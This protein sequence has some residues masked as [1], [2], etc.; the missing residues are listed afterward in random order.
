MSRRSKKEAVGVALFP[1]LAVLICTMG[2]LIVLLVLMV[3]QARD[4][5]GQTLAK[6]AGVAATPVAN[7]GPSAEEL[8]AAKE[9][10]EDAKWR[11]E[12]LVQQRQ[13]KADE[14]SS[15][16][17]ELSHL[18]DHIRRL[19]EQAQALINRVKELDDGKKLKDDELKSAKE[20]LAELKKKIDSKKKEIDEERKKKTG[21]QWYALIPYD[22]PNGTRRRPFYIECVEEGIIIQPEGLLLTP[23]DFNGP[24]G[25]GN[26]L[27]AALRAK[28]EYIHEVTGGKGGEPYPLLVVRPSGVLAYSAARAAMRAWDEE[29]GYELISE[30]KKLDF[31]ARDPELDKMLAKTV[32]VARQRQVMLAAAMPRKYQDG[33]PTASFSPQES[34][35]YDPESS[36][37]AAGMGVGGGSG[38]SMGAMAAGK[39]ANGASGGNGLGGSDRTAAGGFAGGTG[40]GGNN[41]LGGTG[42]AGGTGGLGTAP[43]GNKTR[44]SL[45]LGSPSGGNAG[46]SSAAGGGGG[47]ATGSANG[48][49]GTNEQVAGT[50]GSGSGTGTGSG[51]GQGINAAGGSGVA[52]GTAGSGSTSSSGGGGGSP[53]PGQ[54]TIAMPASFGNMSNMTGTSSQAMDSGATNTDPRMAEA[55]KPGMMKSTATQESGGTAASG[56]SKQNFAAGKAPKAGKGRTGGA[57]KANNWGLPD[58]RDRLTGIT[59]PIRVTCESNRLLILPDKGEAGKPIVIPVSEELT[60]VEVQTFVAGVQKNMKSWGLAV[61]GGYWKPVLNVHVNPDAEERFAELQSVLQGSGFDIARKNR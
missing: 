17:L 5:V 54:N 15:K 28:R 1:F 4:D 2:S 10:A 24:L 52:G 56:T 3:Q 25:P 49:A 9:A 26:P 20:E 21:E 41:A 60:P 6:E 45:S 14:L 42:M 23:E 35:N 57:S 48:P 61:A 11:Q 50:A 38:S 33:E 22:G 27:D 40:A 39:S 37:G 29:F 36:G 7:K 16:R 44:G 32:T 53:Q 58:A 55:P 46:T 12:L 19:E 51:G 31:G 13:E 47:D 30:E 59:R 8:L 18:E 43:G 34:S